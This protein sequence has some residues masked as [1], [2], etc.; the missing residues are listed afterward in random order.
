MSS[1]N[2]SKFIR[3]EVQIMVATIAFGMGIDKPDVRFVIHDSLPRNIESYY[4]ETGRAGRD[5][6]P[7]HCLLFFS[8]GDKRNIEYFFQ[9]ITD[10]AEL[11]NAEEKLQQMIDFCQQKKC[12]RKKLLN[13][14]DE[15]Y[16]VADSRT[17][18]EK[19]KCC[20]FCANPPET[21]DATEISFKIFSAIV[22][23]GQNLGIT[24]IADILKGS[25]NQKIAGRGF[26]NLSVFGIVDNFS[27]KS[28]VEIMRQLI[29]SGFMKL[30]TGDYPVVKIT[31]QAMQALQNKEQIT[32]FEVQ[33]KPKWSGG[34][35]DVDFD[36][37]EELFEKLRHLRTK[38]ARDRELPP[39][40]I[41]HDKTLRQMAAILPTTPDIL[42]SISG[43]GQNKINDFG[44]DFM[45]VIKA[46]CAEKNID[47]KNHQSQVDL[48]SINKVEIKIALPNTRSLEILRMV[49]GGKSL[50]EIAKYFEVKVGTIFSHL[51]RL[52]FADKLESINPFVSPEKQTKI[53]EAFA[54]NF[55]QSLSPI[56]EKLGDDFS[57]DEIRLVRAE[58]L[59][60]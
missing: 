15:K 60:S 33:I 1:K 48:Q 31:D 13:Y 22:R 24:T 41:F 55:S 12:R 35:A 47:T 29:E 30:T 2:Q 44:D 53:K 36:F 8:Y 50:A 7:A 21:F 39:Y 37:D 58:G 52:L 9:D 51:E 59:K 23:T 10:P 17:D 25:K 27:T 14:F 43:V 46:F 56:K 49:Q 45:N 18:E 54:S 32:L 38:I 19:Q 6:D 28:L 40:V 34:S 26:E 3:D 4:Q 42:G 16:E 11:K 57:Y 5:G 20:D